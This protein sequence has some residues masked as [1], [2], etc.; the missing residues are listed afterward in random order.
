MRKKSQNYKVCILAAGVG[1]VDHLADHVNRGILPVNNKGVV[2]YMVEKFPKNV[3]IV[4]AVGHKKETIVDYLMLAYPDRKFRFVE[5]KKFT[6]PGT[7]PGHSL[8]TCKKYLQ[9]PFIFATADT[10]VSEDVPRPDTNWMG[11]APVHETEQYCTVKIRNNAIYQLDDKIK[12]DNHFAFIGLAG[13]NDYKTFFK[14][15]ESDKE[16]IA[17][18][19]QVSNG[20]KALLEKHLV[21]VG[22]TWYDT[23]T[24]ENYVETNKNFSGEGK[25]DFSKGN[26]FLYFVNNRVIKFF[27]DRTVTIGATIDPKKL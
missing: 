2:S 22:F 14:A 20:F 4:V 23:G 5:V 13:I 18:E 6:G 25:F 19:I 24:L 10:I 21:P 17:G 7:G 16:S 9:C 3:E 8:L 11:I 26:E 27:A 1:H 15:L 12:T